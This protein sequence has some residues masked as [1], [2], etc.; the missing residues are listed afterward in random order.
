MSV[1]VVIVGG[2][3]IGLFCAARLA[4]TGARVTLLEG[5]RENYSVHGPAASLAAAGM[6]APIG[7]DEPG[8]PEWGKLAWD[9]FGLWR[10][11]SRDALWADGVRF[12]GAAIIPQDEAAARA[13]MARAAALG[14]MAAPLSAGQW[15]KRTGLSTQIDTAIF[16]EDEGVADPGRV[17]SGLAMETLR[18]GGLIHY[19][20]DVEVV[21]EAPLRVRTF[22]NWEYEADIVVIATGAMSQRRLS[23]AAPA[24]RHIR[25][26]KGH[27]VPVELEAPLGA[28]VRA[29]GFYLARR[30][31]RDVVLGATMEWDRYERKVDPERVDG[32]LAAAA[33]VLPGE[34]RLRTDNDVY[35]WAGVRPMTPDGA[36]MIGPSGCV[37]AA[38][39]HS[40][41]GWLL[42]PITA[43]I[44]CAYVYGEP[45]LP[46]WGAFSPDRFETLKKDQ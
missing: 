16:V 37:L 3:V 2:G 36:P 27:L 14:R 46:L 24:L 44:I 39:G 22:D 25:P 21:Q 43:E 20:R 10:A 31:E 5:E 11:W 30:G 13:I 26:A 29:P 45:I 19:A 41:N 23:S 42:A 40:R 28:T 35:P 18:Y 9:S 7:E 34:V 32:L 8:H 6:L 38:A 17:L 1:R 4:R 12:D 33:R 15:R